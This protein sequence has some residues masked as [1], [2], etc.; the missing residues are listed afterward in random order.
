MADVKAAMGGSKVEVCRPLRG[1]QR[2]LFELH[3]V[4]CAERVEAPR[5]PMRGVLVG[6]VV[7]GANRLLSVA[8]Q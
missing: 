1:D 3:S 6:F 2:D 7:G 8:S 4:D 5:A